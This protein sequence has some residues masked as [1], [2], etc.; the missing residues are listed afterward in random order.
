MAD[1]VVEGLDGRSPSVSLTGGEPLLVAGLF[2]LVEHLSSSFEDVALITSGTVTD[3]RILGRIRD[4]AVLTTV[5]VSL[6]SADPAVHDR[7]RGEG[8]FARVR[9][10]I[11]RLLGTGKAVVAMV[12]LSRPNLGSLDRTLRWAEATGLA[13]VVV[14]RFVPL[15]RGRAMAAAALGAGEWAAAVETVLR[16]AGLEAEPE[17][18]APFSA[19]WLSTDPDE[20]ERLRGARC[21]LGDE[22][23]ALMPD[24]T[25]YPCRR[26]P[27]P[28][29]NVL[30]EPFEAILG[31]LARWSPDAVRPRLRSEP[32]ARC[33]VEGCAGCRAAALALRGDPLGG[34]PFCPLGALRPAGASGTR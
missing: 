3:D 31:R 16:A 14:E 2:E 30:A 18:L 17:G 33:A 21:N 24:G 1:R 20:P 29:G 34:D 12:T 10:G 9:A 6:E 13:G 7:I 11:E 15:G 25:V 19:F 8:S 28:Q 23:M 26:L 5:K 27:L 22:S 32:C 4:A